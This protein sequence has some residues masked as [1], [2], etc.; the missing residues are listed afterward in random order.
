[1][2]FDVAAVPKLLLS[3]MYSISREVSGI[4]QDIFPVLISSVLF[5]RIMSGGMR[6]AM[7]CAAAVCRLM[8]A[9]HCG[10]TK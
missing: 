5:V 6:A 3:G 4:L 2:V 7:C 8:G 9:S 10:R 1:M